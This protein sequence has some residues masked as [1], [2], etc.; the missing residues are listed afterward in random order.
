MT[1]ILM[2]L[3]VSIFEKYFSMNLN[4]NTQSQTIVWVFCFQLLGFSCMASGHLNVAS[5]NWDAQ[6]RSTL[7]HENTAQAKDEHVQKVLNEHMLK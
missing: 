6:Y 5:P 4:F 3:D 7:D 1:D 2:Y